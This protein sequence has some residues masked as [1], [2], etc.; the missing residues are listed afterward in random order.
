MREPKVRTGPSKIEARG[1][2]VVARASPSE[3]NADTKG[4]LNHLDSGS[5][6]AS[7]SGVQEKVKRGGAKESVLNWGDDV[8]ATLEGRKH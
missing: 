8:S 2:E 4:G 6:T 1:T 7:Y 3:S 5:R